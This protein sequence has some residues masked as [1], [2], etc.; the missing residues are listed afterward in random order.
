[1]HE[2]K[3]QNVTLEYDNFT[4][5]QENTQI[6]P[7]RT[8]CWSC[9]S[10]TGETRRS[11]VTGVAQVS[12]RC[13]ALTVCCWET[14][15]S[16]SHTIS[17]MQSEA[18]RGL[19]SDQ[20]SRLLTAADF[21]RT[22]TERFPQNMWATWILVRTAEPGPR[23]ED[24]RQITVRF[25]MELENGFGSDPGRDSDT[26][27][28]RERCVWLKNNAII[29][30]QQL[31]D[32]RSVFCVYTQIPRVDPDQTQKRRRSFPKYLI[33]LIFTIIIL[34]LAGSSSLL[35]YFLGEE[36]VTHAI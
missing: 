30:Q 20:Q 35:W 13:W 22:N 27:T 5:V 9:P 21:G 15:Y 25:V 11:D 24:E 18:V 34:V 26:D 14:R 28:V 1:M 4:S 2:L 17:A 31:R 19:S 36:R 29:A 12:A 8:V 7:E 3:W 23:A 32:I 16:Y 6:R 33:G 10:R